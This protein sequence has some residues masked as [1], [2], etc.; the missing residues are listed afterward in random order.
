MIEAARAAPV[1]QQLFQLAPREFA[2]VAQKQ[3]RIQGFGEDEIH[4][5]AGR[6]LALCRLDTS[7]DCQF[8]IMPSI[9]KFKRQISYGISRTQPP[10]F[11]DLAA[12]IGV[13]RSLGTLLTL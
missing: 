13:E 4:S 8:R 7:A 9:P 10:I 2:P 6:P 1:L 5:I 12:N 11:T 3:S